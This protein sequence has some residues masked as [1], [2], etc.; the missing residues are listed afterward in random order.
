MKFTAFICAS[1]F[2]FSAQAQSTF[3]PKNLGSGINTAYDEVSP[4][5]SADRKIIFFSR[6]DHPQNGYGAKNSADIWFSTLQPTGLWS[7]AQRSTSLNLGQHNYALS[8]TVDGNTLLVYTD[9]GLSI[10]TKQNEI[11]SA[12]QKLNIKG[13]SDATLSADGKYLLYKKKSKLYILEKNDVG[14][15]WKDAVTAEGI[16]GKIQTP[17]L[18]IDN[19]TLYYS[20]TK[21]GKGKDLFRI[22]RL[23]DDWNVWSAPTHLNDTIN[24]EG[25]ETSLR[26][27]ANGAWG[28]YSSTKNSV[29]KGDIFE[30]KLF[31]DRPYILVSGKIINA[32]SKRVLKG[33][34]IQILVD[35]K[36][37]DNAVN[38]DSA[39]FSVKLPFGKK[40]TI[41]AQLYQYGAKGYTIDATTDKEYREI[42]TDLEE[43]PVTFA[44]LKGKLLIKNTD[45]TI[46]ASA[47]AKIVVDGE[48]MESATIDHAKGTYSIRLNH[49][50]IY[51]IQVS[52]Q[53]FES[54]PDII[55]LKNVDGYEEINFDLQADAEKMAIVTGKIIDKKTGALLSPEI[56]ADVKVE[57][58]SSVA[59]S[60]DSLKSEY[61]LRFPL[62]DRYILSAIASNYY[63]VYESIDVMNE[64]NEVRINRDLTLVPVERGQSVLLKNVFFEPKK[65]TLSPSSFPELDRLVAYL[66][67]NP[68]VKIDVS[69]HTDPST[70]ISTA[71]QAKAI[72]S[73]LTSKGIAKNRITSHGHGSSKPVASNKTAEG[74]ALNRR[75]E[76]TFLEK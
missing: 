25:N 7:E 28:Y 18:L 74:K 11:W 30:V 65:T 12:P 42:K 41:S 31:E 73:Y 57:G 53:R 1:L 9:E 23:S 29:G 61:E 49:G 72:A 5:I 14:G 26:T 59:A 24:T 71:N 34:D 52:A 66:E 19:K 15:G 38:R 43:E 2:V 37:A 17:F 62:K 63:P 45:Q 47:K 22:K 4:V 8:L 48:E 6:K 40:Y 50:T 51:Y 68:T 54:L 76:F 36:Q 3:L 56:K 27:N 60:V 33:K 70:K 10:S 13:S 46:P 75:V 20:T 58:V 21:K 55:D 69:A 44:L 35:G 39:S 32:T 67:A 64:T 16:K